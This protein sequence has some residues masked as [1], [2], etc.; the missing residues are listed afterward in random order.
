MVCYEYIF[1]NATEKYVLYTHQHKT[2]LPQKSHL[3]YV[4]NYLLL[5]EEIEDI[6]GLLRL[7]IFQVSL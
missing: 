4:R 2:A 3:L 1:S 7:V 6:M 5:V